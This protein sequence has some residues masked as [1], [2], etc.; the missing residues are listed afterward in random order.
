MDV[1]MDILGPAWN[2]AVARLLVEA[3][4]G[5]P[6]RRFYEEDMQEAKLTFVLHLRS[7]AGGH[8]VLVESSS[9]RLENMTKGDDDEQA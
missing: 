8:A 7:G 2:Q 3:G 6:L 5:H 9:Y 4:F 1:E